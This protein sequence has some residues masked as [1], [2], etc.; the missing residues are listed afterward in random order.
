MYIA[1]YL[2]GEIWDRRMMKCAWWLKIRSL[3]WLPNSDSSSMK[4]RYRITGVA[5]WWIVDDHNRGIMWITIVLSCLFFLWEGGRY[6]L[7]KKTKAPLKT[8]QRNGETRS[9]SLVH[10]RTLHGLEDWNPMAFSAISSKEMVGHSHNYI[11]NGQE[12]SNI[13]RFALRLPPKW[14]QGWKVKLVEH[15]LWHGGF[16]K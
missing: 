14:I 1:T 2:F 8:H 4:I 7:A 3:K 6:R 13:C 10:S 11:R 16:L 12:N 5:S 9:I 15:Q